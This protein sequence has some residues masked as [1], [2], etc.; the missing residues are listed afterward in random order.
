V[1]RGGGGGKEERGGNNKI[2]RVGK[3]TPPLR[4]VDVGGQRERELPG[5]VAL[6]HLRAKHNAR[7]PSAPALRRFPANILH[8]REKCLNIIFPV[9]IYELKVRV[10]KC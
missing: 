4:D 1:R 5:G 8:L 9:S 6:M 10:M 3:S 7:S 2:C